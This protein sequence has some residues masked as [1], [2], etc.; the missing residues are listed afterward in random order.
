MRGEDEGVDLFCIFRFVVVASVALVGVAVVG[1]AV[2]DLVPG[3]VDGFV[4]FWFLAALCGNL[5]PAQQTR[6]L[7]LTK[8]L[9]SRETRTTYGLRTVVKM[10]L[11]AIPSRTRVR[12]ASRSPS[13]KDPN[14]RA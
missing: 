7:F 14:G 8:T 5:L 13:R 10:T 2:V 12:K 6:L 11:G 3:A 9:K 4:C 1:I